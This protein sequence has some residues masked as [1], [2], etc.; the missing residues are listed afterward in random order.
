MPGL[1][2]VK[3]ICQEIAEKFIEEARTSLV[4]AWA[5]GSTTSTTR[6]VDLRGEGAPS[7]GSDS[8]LLDGL[9]PAS[10]SFLSAASIAFI[11]VKN[12]SPAPS[13]YFASLGACFSRGANVFA[14]NKFV[15]YQSRIAEA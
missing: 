7:S 9:L 11:I 15:T 10:F 3:N 2:G 6:L 8:P 4:A 5:L 13:E 12:R 14:C 1:F